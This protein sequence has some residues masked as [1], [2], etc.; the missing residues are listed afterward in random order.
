MSRHRWEMKRSERTPGG[1]GRG[2]GSGERR[3]LP[4]RGRTNVSN[5]DGVKGASSGF[6]PKD[7]WW[8]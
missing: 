7:N 6:V 8:P 4:L 3:V 1:W 5:T 2:L